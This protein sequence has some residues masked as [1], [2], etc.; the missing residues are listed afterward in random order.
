MDYKSPKDLADYLIYL[1]NNKTAYNSYFDWKEHIVFD[2]P[3]NFSP[4]CDMCVRLNLENYI[5]IKKNIITNIGDYW[6]KSTN[7]KYPAGLNSYSN[8]KF[9]F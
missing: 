8:L 2:E 9:T 1:N 6:S 5:G 3:I 7:C 4:L